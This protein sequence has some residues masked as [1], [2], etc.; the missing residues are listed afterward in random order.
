MTRFDDITPLRAYISLR[1]PTG[2]HVRR[3]RHVR[4]APREAKRQRNDTNT[5]KRQRES[6]A[7]VSERDRK[8]H[9][10]VIDVVVPWANTM[11]GSERQRR[12]KELEHHNSHKLKLKLGKR[13][14]RETERQKVLSRRYETI[15]QIRRRLTEGFD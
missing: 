7:D 5:R 13:V 10:T 6:T 1:G 11:S 15:F 14:C 2:R 3:R 9:R 12:H 8:R 4:V